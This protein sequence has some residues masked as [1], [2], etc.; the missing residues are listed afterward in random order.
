MT[1][2]YVFSGVQ[3]EITTVPIYAKL[4]SF[5]W[6]E[7]RVG[8]EK[9][10]RSEKSERE[11]IKWAWKFKSWTGEWALFPSLA[12]Q[13]LSYICISPPG[14]PFPTAVPLG[15]VPGAVRSVLCSPPAPSCSA[16]QRFSLKLDVWT[17]LCKKMAC[18]SWKKLLPK[19]GLYF[20]DTMSLLEFLYFSLDCIKLSELCGLMYRIIMPPAREESFPQ[21]CWG[22]VIPNVC[23]SKVPCLAGTPYFHHV[24]VDAIYSISNN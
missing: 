11:A 22:Q 10:T 8:T 5:N 9:I 24:R 19:Q 12:R 2:Y 16:L 3:D 18:P 13:K 17:S 4:S 6:S 1:R 7:E 15:G 23:F 21:I 20:G 14:V